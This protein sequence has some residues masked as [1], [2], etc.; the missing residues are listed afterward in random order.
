MGPNLTIRPK[1]GSHRSKLTVLK[2][3]VKIQARP[4]LMNSSAISI[5][6]WGGFL[7]VPKMLVLEVVLE[8]ATRAMGEIAADSSRT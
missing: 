5:A 7:A 3:K 4:I 2:T 8:V 6:S 1:T